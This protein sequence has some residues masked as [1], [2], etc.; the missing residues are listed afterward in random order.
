MTDIQPVLVPDIGDL[1]DVSVIELLVAEGDA[2][3]KDQGLLTLESDKATLEVPAPLSGIVK[4]LKVRVG[5]TVSQG[6]V[7]A[8]IA[9][10]ATAAPQT[11]INSSV[12]SG[13]SA[14]CPS[15]VPDL[16]DVGA[17]PVIEVLVQVGQMVKQDQGL[18][19][20]ESDKATIEVPSVV[21]GTV[22]EILVKEGDRLVTGQ[23]VATIVPSTMQSPL[24]A[25]SPPS[26]DQTTLPNVTIQS[27]QHSPPKASARVET[28]NISI[29]RAT[30]VSALPYASPSVRLLARECGVDLAQIKGSGRYGRITREDLENKPV[31]LGAQAAHNT[32]DGATV[33]NSP[34]EGGAGLPPLGK[35]DFAKFG[36]VSIQPLTRIKKL[37]G[38]YL[39]RNWATIPHVTQ[40]DQADVTDLEA[41]RVQINRE[42]AA[43]G[44]KLTLLAFL[45]KASVAA[46]QAFPEVN[47]SL[48][49][50]GQQLVMKE[51]Y[52][53]GFAA[54]TDQGLVVLVVRDVERKGV[55]A[56]SEEISALAQ[57]ARQGKIS[58]ADTQG[59]CFTISSLGGIGG[60]GFTPI[61]NAPEVAILG[62]SRAS[63]QPVW[64]GQ[65][66][67]PRLLL[68]LALSYDHR[69]IDGALA[70]RFTT[71]LQHLLKDLRRLIL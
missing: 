70:A 36:P 28:S 9:A 11:A 51:Y 19:V 37:S 39:A 26:K 16:G 50:S 29:A 21:A 6:N 65:A 8:L 7:V 34:I 44:V 46:L 1:R 58:A 43:S 52:H 40:F 47:S 71:H 23:A 45:M 41:L 48:D 5:A 32:A 54:D 17:L 4:E 63:M 24:P 66:F 56:L 31:G 38:G 15:I 42:K 35:V 12:A 10:A 30:P 3:I 59:G 61:I 68:P 27:A 49:S 22:T 14:A 57:Q 2:V 60:T 25:Q 18:V 53:V 13:H 33:A 20:L 67:V 69:V 64:D 62:V 55:I